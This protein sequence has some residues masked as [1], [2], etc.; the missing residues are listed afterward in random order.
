LLKLFHRL[1]RIPKQ[2]LIAYSLIGLIVLIGI[3]LIIWGIRSGKI[4]PRAQT[5]CQS[6]QICNTASVTYDGLGSPIESNTV[7]TTLLSGATLNFTIQLQGRTNHSTNN[8]VLKVFPVGQ[9]NPVL[10]RNDLSTDSAGHGTI[11]L[12]DLSSGNYDFKLKAPNNLT[13]A[14]T[15]VAIVDPLSID[16]G[17]LKTGDLD[18]NDIING[19]DFSRMNAKWFQAD[20]N[21]DLN[22]DGI[23]NGLDFALMNSN[24]FAQGE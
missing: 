21:A 5:A 6:G 3:G 4:K 22:Q 1:K 11:V 10:E 18:S 9:T 20:P 16:F 23:V 8:T 12:T 19:L 24:W 7:I 14:R 13:R 15:N 17:T 2:K